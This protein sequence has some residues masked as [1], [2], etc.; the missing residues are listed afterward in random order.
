MFTCST[1]SLFMHVC[2]YTQSGELLSVNAAY[3]GNK[4]KCVTDRCHYQNWKAGFSTN[5]QIFGTQASFWAYSRLFFAILLSI[6]FCI[7]TLF[8]FFLFRNSNTYIL[9][10]ADPVSFQGLLIK[11]ICLLSHSR[12]SHIGCSSLRAYLSVLAH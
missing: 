5:Y 11:E 7:W 2:M 4:K 1:H 6:S 9:T 12:F 3:W 10:L 8:W